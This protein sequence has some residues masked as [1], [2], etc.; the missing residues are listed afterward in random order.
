[1]KK[2]L[3]RIPFQNGKKKRTKN[4]TAFIITNF[5][6]SLNS[7]QRQSNQQLVISSRSEG[8]VFSQKGNK[9][10]LI[11]VERKAKKNQ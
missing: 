11:L 10:K 5:T 4:F 1:M 3:K 6:V 7:K 8:V 2:N 9:K